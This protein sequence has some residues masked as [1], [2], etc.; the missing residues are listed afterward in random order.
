MNPAAEAAIC[1]RNHI[2]PARQVRE[3]HD[4]VRHEVRML[5]S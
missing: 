3:T 4:P 5:K 2:F 1:G